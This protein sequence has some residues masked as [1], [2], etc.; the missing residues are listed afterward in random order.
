MVWLVQMLNTPAEQTL[1]LF[2]TRTCVVGSQNAQDHGMGLLETWSH[3]HNHSAEIFY[4]IS[5]PMEESQLVAAAP[6]LW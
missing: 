2:Y 6:L 1:P 4:S 3:A 5:S